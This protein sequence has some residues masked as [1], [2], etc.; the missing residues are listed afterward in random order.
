M[1]TIKKEIV[2]KLFKQA[3][4]GLPNEVCGY[5]AGKD[6]QILEH[7]EL[8]NL[9]KSPEHFSMDPKEQFNAVKDAREK[10]YKIISCYHSHPETPARPSAEDIKL[11]YDPNM[12]YIIISLAGGSKEIKGY[13]IKENNVKEIKLEVV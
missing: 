12:I 9:D 5:L 13:E 4:E 6:N 10:G 8:T 1:V 2:E 11:A 3:E 7:Y